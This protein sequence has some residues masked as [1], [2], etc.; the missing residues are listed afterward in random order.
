MKDTESAAKANRTPFYITLE[1]S[2]VSSEVHYANFAAIH[3]PAILMMNEVL[4]LHFL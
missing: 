2:I 4:N 3:M 1:C